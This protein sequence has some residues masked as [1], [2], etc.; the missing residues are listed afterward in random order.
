MVSRLPSCPFTS[1][2]CLP[3]LKQLLHRADLLGEPHAAKDRSSTSSGFAR[4]M[5]CPNL[6]KRVVVSAW[7]APQ[8]RVH[9]PTRVPSYGASSGTYT[10]SRLNPQFQQQ[11]MEAGASYSSR[12]A[13]ASTV[14]CLP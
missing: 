10:D 11:S 1:A 14:V 9:A 3:V 4:A 2:V 12:P 13:Q 8:P 7:E 5:Q 6:T